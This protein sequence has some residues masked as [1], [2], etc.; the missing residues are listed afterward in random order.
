MLMND[1]SKYSVYLVEE[2]TRTESSYS[3]ASNQ[4]VARDFFLPNTK[5]Y[6]RQFIIK[7]RGQPKFK[8]FLYAQGYF[9]KIL[10]ILEDGQLNLK[11]LRIKSVFTQKIYLH[12]RPSNM[13]LWMSQDKSSV[14]VTSKGITKTQS[15]L[16]KMSPTLFPFNIYFKILFVTNL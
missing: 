8:Y 12:S 4:P 3:F 7:T 11:F 5:N 13:W 10:D 1:S 2:A 14:L 9:A 15:H 16:V 6:Y